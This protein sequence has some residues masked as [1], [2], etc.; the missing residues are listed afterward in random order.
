[1]KKLTAIKYTCDIDIEW[2]ENIEEGLIYVEKAIREDR[3]FIRTE[4]EVVPIEKVKRVSKASV[5]HLSRHSDLITR[6]P[7]DMNHIIPDKLYV[8]EKLSDYLVYENRFLYMLLCYLKDFIQMRLDKIRD[9]TT[10]YQSEMF[11]D[12]SVEAN[13]RQLKYALNYSDVYKNDPFLV[14]EY[15]K[16]KYVDRLETIYAMVVSFFSDTTNERSF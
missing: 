12:K 14:D 3:Q 8:V 13:Q 16:I 15:K 1:M 11:M 5:E 2:I 10:T 7:K 4:G 6:A 9:K